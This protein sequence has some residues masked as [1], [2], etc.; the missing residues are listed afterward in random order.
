MPELPWALTP[1]TLYSASSRLV[2]RCS[3][4]TVSETLPTL[5]GVSRSVSGSLLVIVLESGT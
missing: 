5:A 1:A 2:A 3:R 4:S